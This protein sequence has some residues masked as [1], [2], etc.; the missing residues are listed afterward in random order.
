MLVVGAGPTGLALA[1]Q[2]RT[3]DTPFRIVDRSLDRARESRAPAIQPRTL[4]MLAGLGVT[5]DLVER[6]STAVRLHLGT[7]RPLPPRTCLH[8]RT[9]PTTTGPSGGGPAPR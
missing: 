5:D 4:E 3:Y 9:A 1:T 6:G 2:L 7:R 8:H